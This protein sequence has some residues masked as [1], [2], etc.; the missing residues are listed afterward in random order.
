LGPE[1]LPQLVEVVFAG[2]LQVN[3]Q[4]GGEVVFQA[5][6]VVDVPVAETMWTVQGPPGSNAGQPTLIHTL[7]D[8]RHLDR[9][10]KQTAE[11]L[12][13]RG[14]THASQANPSDRDAWRA[15][16]DARIRQINQ[17]LA[18]RSR[19]VTDP[20][21]LARIGL[22]TD[23]ASHWSAE[24]E[25]DEAKVHC[26]LRGESARLS[27]QFR[28]QTRQLWLMRFAS[29]LLLLAVGGCALW[30]VRRDWVKELWVRSPQL[31]VAGLGV[32]WWLLCTPSVLGLAV[33]LLSAASAMRPRWK[34]VESRG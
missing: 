7:A 24:A 9:F 16:W 33:L 27:I 28:H 30:F 21:A 25:R 14:L 15:E 8:V 2:D 12:L 3:P 26:L 11:S 22:P 29:L 32:A 5:P 20:T 17:R 13:R 1:L 34:A 18:Q 6:V 10:R 23:L 4:V 19:T 31:F